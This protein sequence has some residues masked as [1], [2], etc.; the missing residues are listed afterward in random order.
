[1][2]LNHEIVQR[3]RA[4]EEQRRPTCMPC[5]CQIRLPLIIRIAN[6]F[7]VQVITL[8]RV[9]NCNVC[10]HCEQTLQFITRSYVDHAEPMPAFRHRDGKLHIPATVQMEKEIACN[11]NASKIKEKAPQSS[12]GVSGT[13]RAKHANIPRDRH[14][15]NCWCVG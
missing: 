3:F 7:P 11:R 15:R 1:M 14:Q 13:H 9:I 4:A 2:T 6:L 10:S 8:V 5:R 12:S